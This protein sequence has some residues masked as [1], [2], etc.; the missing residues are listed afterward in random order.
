MKKRLTLPSI[1]SLLLMFMYMFSCTDVDIT[2]PKG[3]KGDKGDRGLSAYEIWKEEVIAGRIIWSKDEV[4]INDFFRYL[5]G[6]DGKDGKDGL[7]PHIGDNGNWWI[8]DKDTGVP[9]KGKDGKDGKTPYVGNNGNWWIGDKDTGV[10]AMGKDGKSAY[11]VWK[12]YIASGDVDD[13]HNP[14]KKWDPKKNTERDFWEFLAGKTGKDGKDGKDGKTPYIGDNGNWWIGDKDTGVPAKG[15]DGKD[16][17]D[18]L[19]P[20]IG[21]NGNWWIGDKDTGV[22]AKGKDG[23]SAYEL[24]VEEVTKRCGTGNPVMDPHDPSKPWPCDKIS[25]TDFWEYL[26]GKDGKDGKDGDT[27]I[28]IEHGA[29]NVLPLYFNGAYKEYVNPLD[30]SVIVQVFDKDGAKVKE[31]VEVQGLPGMDPNLKYTTDEKG[32]FKI[33]SKD[34]P[35]NKELK[36]RKGKV[37]IVKIK[38]VV[39]ESAPNTIIPNKVLTRIK[40]EFIYPR[41][42]TTPDLS[43]ASAYNS[44]FIVI[45]YKYERL[46]D[47]EW[48]PYPEEYPKPELKCVKVADINKAIDQSN[49][50]EGEKYAKWGITNPPAG[51]SDL[52]DAFLIIRPNVLSDAE[53]KGDKVMFGNLDKKL[54]QIKRYEWKETEEYFFSIKG[55]K[56]FYGDNPIMDEAVQIPE[57][58]PSP[59][60]K[61]AVVETKTGETNTWGEIEPDALKKFYLKYDK[62]ESGKH[63]WTIRS[64]EPEKLLTDPKLKGNVNFRVY[65]TKNKNGSTGTTQI[66]RSYTNKPRS[67]NFALNSTFPKNVLSVSMWINNDTKGRYT[68]DQERDYILEDNYF[69]YRVVPDYILVKEGDEYFGV[70]VFDNTDIWK[71]ETGEMP[72]DWLD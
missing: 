32:Q 27:G 28:V 6:K 67:I 7:N 14:G 56:Y 9:A 20:R 45:K 52:K 44:H 49:I 54:A 5:K 47:K 30:G 15:K 68:Q 42:I 43:L 11:E 61:C 31:G 46:L 10:P 66:D 69:L 70:K 13:P 4:Q 50:L 24:W 59:W 19:S 40:A 41:Q 39:T 17:K 1:V 26:R 62:P 2:M 29:P 65:M 57:I 34:L 38:G 33:E 18:G 60:L 8:G 21:D 12:D 58:Y 64:L 48:K 53:K 3:P 23:K 22:P 55:E 35:R 63:V 25:L 36:D 71:L 72:V 37:K 51:F 16:G